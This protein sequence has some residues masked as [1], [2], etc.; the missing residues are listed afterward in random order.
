MARLIV[1]ICAL[2][3]LA[4]LPAVAEP[5]NYEG[6]WW[7]AP[8]GSETGWRIRLTQRGAKLSAFWTIHGANDSPLWSYSV[9]ATQT[10]P[11][12]F[13]GTVYRTRVSGEPGPG[14]HP[15]LQLPRQLGIAKFVFVDERKGSLTA[16]VTDDANFAARGDANTLQLSRLS[17][18]AY[19]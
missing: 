13:T 5:V 14:R 17:D 8:V 10:A 6:L 4:V 19:P 1:W 16:Q 18:S 12:T 2:L 9:R 3:L 11:N 15:V 7:A